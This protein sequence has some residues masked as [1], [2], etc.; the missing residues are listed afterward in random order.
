M[1]EKLQFPGLSN[2]WTMPVENRLDMELT[3]I[4]TPLGMKVQGPNV[5]GI[6]QLASQIQNVLSGMP[7]MRSI[8][9]EKVAQGFYVNVEV[10]RAEAARYG[11]SVAVIQASRLNP[12]SAK[13]ERCRRNIRGRASGIPSTSV[14]REIFETTSIRCAAC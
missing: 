8:F 3:G 14:I 2:T 9:A 7:E 1:D 12:V 5:E 6:Q 4:K 10:N 11:L 13:A